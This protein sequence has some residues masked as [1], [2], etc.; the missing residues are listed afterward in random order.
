MKTISTCKKSTVI[1]LKIR[2]NIQN[3]EINLIKKIIIV[4]YSNYFCK[5]Q[6]KRKMT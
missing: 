3:N 5:S 1:V 4:K 6:M 2:E